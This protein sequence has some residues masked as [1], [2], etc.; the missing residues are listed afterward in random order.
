MRNKCLPVAL[1]LFAGSLSALHAQEAT[2]KAAAEPERNNMLKV[3]MSALILKNISLQ[4]ERK[5]SR[6]VTLALGA[7]VLPFGK[8]PFNGLVKQVVNDPS[9]PID[10]FRLGSSGITPEIRWYLSKRGAFHGFYLGAFAAFNQYKTDLPIQYDND[11]KT[12]V[13][14]GTL[15]TFTGG[16]QLG[17]QWNLGRR[18]YLDWWIIGPNV[19]QGKGTLAFAGVLSP[20]DQDDIRQAIEDVRDDFPVDAIES[21]Q[22]NSQGASIQVKGPWLG[23]RGMAFNLGFRF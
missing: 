20:T 21:Y 17:A 5:I 11:T 13:F 22:V 14:N 1:L 6:K 3:N 10:D 4:Y 23:L 8:V 9:V 16:L 2:P 15:K 12:G 7:H 18:I 19:G